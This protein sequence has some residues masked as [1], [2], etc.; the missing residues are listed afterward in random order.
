LYCLSFAATS[1]VGDDLSELVY[2]TS[3]EESNLEFATQHGKTDLA[4]GAAAASSNSVNHDL[5]RAS[6]RLGMKMNGGG[7]GGGNMGMHN[8]GGGGMAFPPPTLTPSIVSRR[9]LHEVE[10]EDKDEDD[11]LDTTTTNDLPPD[12]STVKMHVVEEVGGNATTTSM[13]DECQCVFCE[14][15]Q[16]CGGLWFGEEK[17]GNAN[18]FVSAVDRSFFTNCYFLLLS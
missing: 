8:G 7:G 11:L 17:N 12:D 16:L 1:V 5:I 10:D 3:S 6:R 13:T 2:R 14:E 18:H 4:R 9:F 15:D